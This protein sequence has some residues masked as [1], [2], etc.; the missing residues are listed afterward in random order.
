MANNNSQGT[1]SPFLPLTQEHKDLL[2]WSADDSVLN[3]DGSWVDGMDQSDP[4]SQKRAEVDR[5]ANSLGLTEEYQWQGLVG[6]DSCGEG[7]GE[8]VYYLYYESGLCEE[9]ATLLQYLL[10]ALDAEAYPY[11][12]VEGAYTCSKLR[13][14]EFGGWACHITRD[15]IQWGGTSSWLHQQ[16][17]TDVDKLLL[18]KG[19][20]WDD[21]PDFPPADWQYEVANGDTRLGYLDWC[22]SQQEMK[23][24]GADDDLDG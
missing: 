21:V 19:K 5:I 24:E 15:D 3:S 16:T 23:N 22:N 2:N 17:L 14:G 9:G 13:P 11:I 7:P 8:R 4:V 6:W 12:Q 20:H 10:K 18:E 1:V